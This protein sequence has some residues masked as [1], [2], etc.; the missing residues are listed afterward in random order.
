MGNCFGKPKT[1]AG[2][3]KKE[4]Q[5]TQPEAVAK[6]VAEVMFGEGVVIG[7]CFCFCFV[8]FLFCFCFVF[9]FLFCFCFVLFLFLLFVFVFNFNSFFFLVGC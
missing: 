2:K 3:Q 1:G 8:L 5:E 9:L 7:V 6:P 4:P